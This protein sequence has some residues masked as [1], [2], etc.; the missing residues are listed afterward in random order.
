MI[1]H[2]VKIINKKIKID[3]INYKGIFSP[4]I[5]IQVGGEGGG[6]GGARHSAIK[7]KNNSNL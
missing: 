4:F 1:N 2:E 3:M 7:P 6:Y 5:R